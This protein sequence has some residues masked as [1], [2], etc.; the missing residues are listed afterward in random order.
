MHTQNTIPLAVQRVANNNNNNN[1]V[2]KD[3]QLIFN[4]EIMQI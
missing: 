3:N 1:F 2:Q 4:D